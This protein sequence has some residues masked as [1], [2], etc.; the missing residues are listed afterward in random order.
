MCSFEFD[1]TGVT[2]LDIEVNKKA[3]YNNTVRI[4]STLRH[5]EESASIF[6]SRFLVL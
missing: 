2:L 4:V 6:F 3:V 1:A 5:S